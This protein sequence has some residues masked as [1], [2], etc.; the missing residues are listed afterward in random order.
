[1]YLLLR[2]DRKP[3]WA[4]RRSLGRY[5]PARKIQSGIPILAAQSQPVYTR[6]SPGGAMQLLGVARDRT[7]APSSSLPE[8]WQ[9]GPSSLPPACPP[10]KHLAPE[11]RKQPIAAL[12]NYSICSFGYPLRFQSRLCEA[13]GRHRRRRACRGWRFGRRGLRRARL[14][15][16]RMQRAASGAGKGIP[17]NAWAGLNS[18]QKSRQHEKSRPS[19]ALRLYLTHFIF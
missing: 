5:R 6:L 2:D 19:F 3:I 4:L 15:C 9:D 18:H 8:K 14:L 11:R 12:W 1:V 17:A 13:V 7:G 16:L 10:K